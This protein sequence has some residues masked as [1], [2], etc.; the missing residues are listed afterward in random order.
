MEESEQ[1]EC[2]P[3]LNILL[4]EDLEKLPE[5]DFDDTNQS[6]QEEILAYT[7]DDLH[8][9]NPADYSQQQVCSL[10]Q[11]YSINIKGFYMQSLGH[12]VIYLLMGCVISL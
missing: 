2:E 3:D 10:N 9:E 4:D 8:Q 12:N 7:G 1:I 6:Q 5:A 11:N